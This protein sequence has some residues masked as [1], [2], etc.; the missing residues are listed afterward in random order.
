VQAEGQ[1][2]NAEEYQRIV[3]MAAP[4][5][6]RQGY[7]GASM[8][9]RVRW[10]LLTH[11]HPDHSPATAALLAIIAIVFVL[12]LANGAAYDPQLLVPMGAILPMSYLLARHEY[13]R[14]LTG[15]FLHEGWLHWAANSW[16]LFQLG[17][18]FE[19]MFGTRRFLLIYFTT[20]LVASIASSS[21]MPLG[22]SSVGASGAILGVLGAFIFSIRRSPQWRHEPW[23]KSLLSQLVFWAILNLILGYEIPQIDNTAHIA[24]LVTGLLMGFLPHRVPPPPPSRGV[25]D[26]RPYDDGLSF[27][28]DQP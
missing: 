18:L 26:V 16:A 11:T 23:T 24:G 10:V 5:F 3:E 21:R 9:E 20:G 2:N 17:A 13:W 7:V 4:V 28:Q 15:M 25:I 6:N 1:L 27:P 14:L 19:I 22:G 12:E 8:R